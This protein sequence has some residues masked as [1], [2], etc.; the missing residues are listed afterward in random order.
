M[1]GLHRETHRYFIE[2]VSQ[3]KH[4]IFNLYKR[5]V[6]FV[7]CMKKSKKMSLRILCD[8]V[9]ADCRSTAGR[10]MRTLMLRFNAEIFEELRR[11]VLKDSTYKEVNENDLWKIK[12]V[13]DLIDAKFD[14]A[15][16]PNFEVNEIDDIRNYIS[17]C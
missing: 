14:R 4:I 13:K 12:A 10:N 2:P 11:N 6:K 8:K 9:I 17:T 3:T 15:I 1:L 5:F 7:D 16:L